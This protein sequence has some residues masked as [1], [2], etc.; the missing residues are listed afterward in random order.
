[1]R[2]PVVV[3]EPVDTCTLG[4]MK[5]LV[6]T[7]RHCRLL[8]LLEMLD[9]QLL[10]ALV[11]HQE[12]MDQTLFLQALLQLVVV[13]VVKEMGLLTLMEI[14]VALAVAVE[15]AKALDQAQLTKDSTEGKTQI[16]VVMVVVLVVVLAQ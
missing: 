12:A 9:I 6:E 1:M 2:Q 14:M 10:L 3:V 4:T 5:L 15:I 16:L 11:A 7:A 8:N 13:L